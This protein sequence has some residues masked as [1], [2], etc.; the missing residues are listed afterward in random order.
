MKSSGRVVLGEK[1]VRRLEFRPLRKAFTPRS[2]QAARFAC[3]LST[4]PAVRNANFACQLPR[5]D[6]AGSQL[7]GELLG[8]RNDRQTII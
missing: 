6:P 5:L 1:N 2:T 4:T 7:E 8:K 3:I